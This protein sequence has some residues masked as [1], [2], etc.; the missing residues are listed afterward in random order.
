MQK[1]VVIF[2][3]LLV[4]ALVVLTIIIIIRSQKLAELRRNNPKEFIKEIYY[5]LCKAF[6]IYG[7]PR[8][9][10]VAYREFYN[11]VKELLS[12]NPEPMQVLTEGFMEA[13][14]SSHE[15]SVEHSQKAI[16]LFHQVKN[17]ILEREERNIFW[18]NILFRL[19]V[20]DVLLV[21]RQ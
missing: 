9:N 10:Y 17:V 19:S 5:A 14:F 8:F 12:A 6:K 3:W 15:I 1:L 11:L 18:K 2:L 7:I 16:D 4:L 13:R 21:P 20:L